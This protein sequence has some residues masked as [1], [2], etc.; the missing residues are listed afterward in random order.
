MKKRGAKTKGSTKV[1]RA[2]KPAIARAA[3]KAAPATQGSRTTSYT[4]PP[5]KSDGWPPFRYPLQ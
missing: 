5:L 2:A 3:T 1:K 4:P